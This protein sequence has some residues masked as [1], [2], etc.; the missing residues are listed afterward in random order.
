[1]TS[2]YSADTGTFLKDSIRQEID[3]SRTDQNK[4]VAPPPIEKTIASPGRQIELARPHEWH[5]IG[6]IDLETAIGRRESRRRFLN[7]PLTL[8]ELSFLLWATQ[9][10]RQ[11]LDSG[12]DVA[13]CALRW[14]SSFLRDLPLRPERVG[15]GSGGVSL[16]SIGTPIV[17]RIPRRKD[18][19]QA[20]SSDA[21]P[22]IC[23]RCARCLRLDNGPLPHGMA[24]RFGGAQSD[25]HRR[26]TR[27]SESL[28]CLRSHRCGYVRNCR[29]SS[30]VDGPASPS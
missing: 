2:R 17:V 21:W 27:L 9:G 7:E 6:S 3:F 18:G 5:G 29:L 23:R 4:G 10:V 12:T 24:I 25:R 28:S 1:M 14:C 11:Q 13:Y 20:R 26:G 8:D 19:P 30:G 22:E 16:S 15:R